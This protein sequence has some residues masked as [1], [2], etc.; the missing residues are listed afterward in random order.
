MLSSRT[1][2]VPVAGCA[3]QS[4]KQKHQDRNIALKIQ[5]YVENES[6]DIG[7]ASNMTSVNKTSS[8]TS[9][10]T[11]PS[12][13]ISSD[14]TSSRMTSDITSPRMTA[15]TMKSSDVTS[16]NVTSSDDVEACDEKDTVEVHGVMVKLRKKVPRNIEPGGGHEAL[17]S[18]R[19]KKS[20][21]GWSQE[22]ISGGFVFFTLHI[23]HGTTFHVILFLVGSLFYLVNSRFEL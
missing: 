12:Q 20:L 7:T 18:R 21:C 19:M 2:N 10:N 16:S 14:V 13:M 4:K 15:S 11:T 1:S 9:V 8:T 22:D 17:L 23:C 5:N 3:S 6:V